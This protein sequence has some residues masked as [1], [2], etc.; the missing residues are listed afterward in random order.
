VRK[1]TEPLKIMG[2]PTRYVKGS[3]VSG[4]DWRIG[5]PGKSNA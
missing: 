1:Y 3:N 2:F 4:G 5:K